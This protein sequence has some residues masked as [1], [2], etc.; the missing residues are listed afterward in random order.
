MSEK[1]QRERKKASA[2]NKSLVRDRSYK[3]KK[4]DITKQKIQLK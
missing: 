2:R 1:E 4:M 3:E